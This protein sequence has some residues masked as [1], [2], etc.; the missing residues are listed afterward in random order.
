VRI[1]LSDGST[2]SFD[3]LVGADGIHSRV[4]ALAFGDETRFSRFLG[5]YASAFILDPGERLVGLGDAFYL[6]T[7]PERQVCIY[8]IR[9][10]RLA[11]LFIHKARRRLDYLSPEFA[12]RELR[13]AYCD[14]DW[15]VPGLLG[16][17]DRVK[18]LYFDA[19]AQIELPSWSAG[20]VSLVGDACGC[21]SL[22]AGQGASLAMAEAEV[23]AAELDRAESDPRDAL[24]RYEARLEPA[25]VFK[26]SLR[27]SDILSSSKKKAGLTPRTF[28]R[29]ISSLSGHH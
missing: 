6:L 29:L 26:S 16:Q 24:A 14:L 20:R 1:L 18:S 17:L 27:V 2:D 25:V 28:S 3:L 7:M 15:V 23:L 9:G 12:A 13:A 21:V 8:P 11:T 10:D 22:L 19:V 4:R 5:Y